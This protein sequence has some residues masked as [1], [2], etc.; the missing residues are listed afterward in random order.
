MN[1]AGGHGQRR[2]NGDED[3]ANDESDESDGEAWE[4]RQRV[5]KPPPSFSGSVELRDLA[6]T[7]SG[8]YTRRT[9]TCASGT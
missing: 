9:P 8:T 3:D 6:R 4:E 1:G 7:I 5:L 2:K